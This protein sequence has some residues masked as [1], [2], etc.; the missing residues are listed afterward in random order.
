MRNR[1]WVE[2]GLAGLTAVLTVVTLI[3]REWIEIVFGVDPDGGSGLL[4]WAIVAGLGLATLLF[5]VLA[6]L[7]W[8]HAATEH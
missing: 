4:E 5:A 6:R 1:F 7:E 2:L 3:S 8:R